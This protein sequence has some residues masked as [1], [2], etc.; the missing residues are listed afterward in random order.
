VSL[1]WGSVDF[2]NNQFHV[3]ASEGF[4]PKGYKPR[5]LPMTDELR[6]FFHEKRLKA[7][8]LGKAHKDDFVFLNSVGHETRADAVTT[9]IMK[10]RE[11]IDLADFKIQNVRHTFCTNLVLAN[12]NLENIKALAG[13]A[14]LKTTE[15][16]LHVKPENLKNGLEKIS[17]LQKVDAKL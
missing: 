8:K 9:W 13:H 15:R 5:T 11:E 4:H 16:Y 1:K 14:S 6:S 17:L 2:L 12:E 3:E 10:V 7:M